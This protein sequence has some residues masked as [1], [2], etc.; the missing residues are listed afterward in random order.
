MNIRTL[1]LTAVVSGLATLAV[2]P[3]PAFAYD[4]TS[5]AAINV[6]AAGVGLRGYDPVAYVT[7]RAPQMGKASLKADYGGVTYWFATRA[8]KDQFVADPAR[9]APQ[10]GGFCAMGVALDKKLDGDPQAWNVVDGKLYVFV[11]RDVQQKWLE[12]VPGNLDKAR[13]E[14]P[15][16]KDKAPR[17]L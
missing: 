16:I 14:W 7:D 1:T 11:N 15:L 5:T 3:A 4:V 13:V 6:D 17:D 2:L 8:H 10:F 9:F 12:N